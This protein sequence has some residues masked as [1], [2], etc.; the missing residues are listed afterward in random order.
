[1]EPKPH[2]YHEWVDWQ[3]LPRHVALAAVAAEDQRFP[4]HRGF[5][6]IE[7]RNAWEDYRNGASLRGASTISQQTAKNLFLWSGRDYVRKALE[8]WLTVLMEALWPKERI[9][10]VYLNIAQFSPDTFGVGA[11]SWRYFD[12]PAVA[13]DAS[14][15]ALL[16]AVLPNP[17][18]YRLDAPSAKVRDRAAWI[19]RQMHRLGGTRY[20]DRL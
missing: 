10:E 15:A 14:Q 20:L 18:I 16:A 9:L 19:R 7:I 13:L 2:V 8:V 1:A 3:M 11:A 5:D 6:L 12:R 4:T 17:E